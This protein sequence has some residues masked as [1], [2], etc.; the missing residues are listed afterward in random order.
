MIQ[1]GVRAAVVIVVVCLVGCASYSRI[2][3]GPVAAATISVAADDGWN[4]LAATPLKKGGA[5]WTR[6]GELLNRLILLP[7]IE[8]GHTLLRRPDKKE[9]IPPFRAD[10]LPHE[11]A[12]LVEA[13]IT[14]SFG[15]GESLVASSGL[16]PSTYGEQ[17]G[18]EFELSV[19]V[20]DGPEYRGSAGGFVVDGRLNL[21]IF[22]AAVPH[23]FDRDRESAARLIASARYLPTP[24]R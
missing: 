18:F 24:E 11:I 13:W 7:D 15:E 14:K 5:M 6:D 9:A 2:M 16:R 23:Y 21:I 8:D 20:S 12:E 17:I 4:A 1:L 10:M 3:P 19:S 22:L